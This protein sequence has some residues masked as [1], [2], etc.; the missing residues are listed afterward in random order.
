MIKIF[1]CPF[2][3]FLNYLLILVSSVIFHLQRVIHLSFKP[4]IYLFGV[5]G[6]LEPQ[7]LKGK[8]GINSGQFT[9]PSQGNT[10]TN[11]HA[12]RIQTYQLTHDACFQTVGR[13]RNARRAGMSKLLA[14]GA[15]FGGVKVCEDQH[16][17][18][19]LIT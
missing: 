7:Q 4:A 1:Y 19:Y 18:K 5:T 15:R 14:K 3:H 16:S 8:G 2:S 9:R 6:L 11:Y 10:E 12:G 17:S 13:S